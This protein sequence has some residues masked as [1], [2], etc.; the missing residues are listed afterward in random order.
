VNSN[1]F[2][3]PKIAQ[4]FQVAPLFDLVKEEISNLCLL[5]RVNDLTLL[6]PFSQKAAYLKI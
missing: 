5:F 2:Q 3:N 4:P 1:L 6:A